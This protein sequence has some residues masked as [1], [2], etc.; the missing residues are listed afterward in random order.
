MCSG[1]KMAVVE[2]LFKYHQQTCRLAGL[3]AWEVKT[4][5]IVCYP[6]RYSDV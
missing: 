1:L 5:R 3:G 2:N 6:A 4:E